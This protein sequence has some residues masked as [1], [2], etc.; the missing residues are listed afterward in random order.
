MLV[1]APHPD[2]E[3]LGVGGTIAKLVQA[4]ASVDVVVMTKAS[5]PL[6]DESVAQTGRDQARAAHEVLG[7]RQTHFLGFPAAGLDTVPHSSVNSALA[8]A[9]GA[10]QPDVV[11]VPFTGDIHR[12]HQLTFLSALVCARP[13]N[14]FPRAIYAYETLSETNWNAPYLSPGFMPNVFVNI[15]DHL[16]AK[17]QAMRCYESEVRSFPHERSIEAITA[18]AAVRGATV[19]LAAAEGFVLLREVFA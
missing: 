4:G 17:L 14:T 3:V 9:F 5:P 7:V 12:D 10:V 8:A 16:E 13:Q 15:A 2:D 11:F 1:V 18:L 6:Y 19:G